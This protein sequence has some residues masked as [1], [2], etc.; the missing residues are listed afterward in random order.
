LERL[1]SQALKNIG[2]A[3]NSEQEPA[4]KNMKHLPP[5]SVDADKE[6]GPDLGLHRPINASGLR[7]GGR[8]VAGEKAV[9]GEPKTYWLAG[10]ARANLEAD[11]EGPVD[12]NA[13]VLEEAE[14]AVG[15]IRGYRVE[16]QVDSDYK[17]LA[18]G[19]TV[20]EHKVDHFPKVTAWKVRLTILKSDST[21]EIRKFGIYLDK[22]SNK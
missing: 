11:M 21:P 6:L 16:G 5:L 4:D 22:S 13:I 20:G 7:G 10:G 8:D 15:R 18:E 14:G 3:S 1:G 12:I 2:Y 17:V 9:D 19:T